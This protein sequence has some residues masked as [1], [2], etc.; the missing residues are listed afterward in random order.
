MVSIATLL[1]SCNKTEC[2]ECYY[3]EEFNGSKTETS[4]GKFC[5]EEIEKKENEV[6]IPSSGTAYYECR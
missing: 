5:D 1:I 6:L 3:I 4:V 2:E